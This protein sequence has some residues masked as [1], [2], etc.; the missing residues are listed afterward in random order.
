MRALFALPQWLFAELKFAV[1][2]G[3][4][5]SLRYRVLRPRWDL[6]ERYG[7]VSDDD[8]VTNI[9]PHAGILFFKSRG[10]KIISHPTFKSRT[11]TRHEPL[12]V[13]K[14]KI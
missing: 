7:H 11:L 9:D 12:I 13:C 3:K 8:A 5:L 6:I 1:N 4:P 14:E 2:V 10:Y